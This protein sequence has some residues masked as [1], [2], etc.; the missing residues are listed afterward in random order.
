MLVYGLRFHGNGIAHGVT[1]SR[2]WTS[3]LHSWKKIISL[4]RGC[5]PGPFPEGCPCVRVCVSVCVFL[6]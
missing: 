2:G 4:A 3:Q 6:V 1:P 5:N